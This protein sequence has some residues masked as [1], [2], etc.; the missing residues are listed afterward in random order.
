MHVSAVR[1]VLQRWCNSECA[2][3]L[4]A[5]CRRKEWCKA[6]LHTANQSKEK[7]TPPTDPR[8]RVPWCSTPVQ[9]MM[10]AN[11]RVRLL[12]SVAHCQNRR[13]ALLLHLESSKDESQACAT[14]KRIM[15]PNPSGQML[16]NSGARMNCNAC[17]RMCYNV[18]TLHRASMQRMWRAGAVGLHNTMMRPDTVCQGDEWC[19]PTPGA[20]TWKDVGRK[21]C[22]HSAKGSVLLDSSDAYCVQVPRLCSPTG[23]NFRFY[24]FS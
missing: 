23:G 12:L 19:A 11:A 4:Q 5:A 22:A 14:T 24:F 1:G 3:G 16:Y 6:S 10:R 15:C 8:K 17:T 2:L 20:C 7:C 21:L 13:C 18:S 9:H